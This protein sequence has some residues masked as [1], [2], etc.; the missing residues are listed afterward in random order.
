M[1]SS[2]GCATNSRIRA[3]RG[4]LIH[5]QNLTQPPALELTPQTPVFAFIT[6]STNVK[7]FT[8]IK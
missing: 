6:T 1:R 7:V 3:F 5:H 2:F 4:R 8:I